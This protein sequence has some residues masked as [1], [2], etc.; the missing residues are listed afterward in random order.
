MKLTSHHRASEQQMSY[1]L[2]DLLHEGRTTEVC[3]DRIAS[4]VAA[5]LAELD[6][7]S[8]LTE[9]LGRAVSAGD[10]AAVHDL[11]VRLSVEVMMAR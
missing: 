3:A 5:W 2:T 4:T 8:P 9:E 1:R 6:A 10:W 11:G 7:R